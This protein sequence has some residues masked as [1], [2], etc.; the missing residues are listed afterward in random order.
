VGQE[1]QGEENLRWGILRINSLLK[2]ESSLFAGLRS[3]RREK[4]KSSIIRSTFYLNK[5]TR[6]KDPGEQVGKKKSG[7]RGK[8]QKKP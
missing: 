7:K 1:G 8:S 4:N 3:K 2:R 6:Q 5:G